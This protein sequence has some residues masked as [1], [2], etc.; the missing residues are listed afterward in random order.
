MLLF[1]NIIFLAGLEFVCVEFGGVFKCVSVFR[2]V[3]CVDIR[4]K[5]NKIR[6]LFLVFLRETGRVRRKFVFV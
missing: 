4:S 1:W 2:C 6:V 3:F 5:G